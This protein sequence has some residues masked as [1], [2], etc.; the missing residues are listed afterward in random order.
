MSSKVKSQN[1]GLEGSR[2]VWF[3]LKALPLQQL[4][5]QARVGGEGE[6]GRRHVLY[7]AY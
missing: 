4:A 2:P 5:F 6:A 7:L 3:R 1:W